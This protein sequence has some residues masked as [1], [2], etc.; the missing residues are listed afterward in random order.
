MCLTPGPLR[1][2]PA[3]AETPALLSEVAVTQEEVAELSLVIV[4]NT[5]SVAVFGTVDTQ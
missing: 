2:A 3:P 5:R 4:G 1:P